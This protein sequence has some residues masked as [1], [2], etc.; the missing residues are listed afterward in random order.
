MTKVQWRVLPTQA[1]RD[2]EQAGADAAREYLKRTGHNNLWV[3]YEAMAA[4]APAAPAEQAWSVV[5]PVSPGAY[6]IRGNGL[7][8]DALVQVIDDDGELRCNLHQRT[9]ETDFGYGYALDDLSDKFEWLGPLHSSANPSA[10]GGIQ[11]DERDEFETAYAE[12]FSKVRGCAFSAHDVAS[13]RDAAG[14]YGDRPY[15]NGQWSGWQARAA[16]EKNND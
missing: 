16:L 2:M 1:N 5:K 9:T 13:M 7:D 3:I 11:R 15:L 6:W 14:G 8:Q 10:V 12:E 4:A